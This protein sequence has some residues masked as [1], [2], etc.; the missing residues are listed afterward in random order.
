MVLVE[1][2]SFTMLG[3]RDISPRDFL[4]YLLA[5]FPF[6]YRWNGNRAAHIESDGAALGFLHDHLVSAGCVD[7]LLG[8]FSPL[9]DFDGK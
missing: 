3:F 9:S 6:V 4:R 7:D 1:F 8:S 2:N 5:L